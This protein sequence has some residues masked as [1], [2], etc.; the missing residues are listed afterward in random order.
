MATKKR[1][2]RGEV[3]PADAAI[4]IRGDL[5][6]PAILADSAQANHEIYGFYGVSVFAETADAGWEEIAATRLRRAE[7]IV[8]FTVGA[9]ID[10]GLEL[11]DTGQSPHFDI[12]HEDLGDLIRR[13]LGCEHRVVPNRGEWQG[14]QP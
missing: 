1:A 2:R 3:L 11:W 4:V 12:V 13:I 14:D 6:D 7:W 9:L 5:L 10:A 8:L